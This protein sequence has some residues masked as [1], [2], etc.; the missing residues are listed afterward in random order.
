MII[1]GSKG[2]VRTVGAGNF[3]CPAC[4]AP[5]QYE[6]KKVQRWFTLYF[7]PVFPTQTL[8]EHIACNACEN[9]Y[10]TKVLEYDPA[11]EEA[12]TKALVAGLWR[13]A[14]IAVACAFGPANM[15][16]AKVINEGFINAW[17]EPSEISDILSDCRAAPSTGM[18]TN[19]V[20]NR[21]SSLQPYLN[22]IGSESFLTLARDVLETGAGDEM[23]RN[24]L[25]KE[26]GLKLDMTEAHIRG[27]L[28]S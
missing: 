24:D 16:Q 4:K 20:M 25:L 6:H 7:V 1:W 2:R 18:E 23:E 28:Y 26:I 22:H 17:N 3:N 19:E 10:T 27:I 8:G 9:T 15:A 21:I 14:L 11:V 13:T 5:R 12:T